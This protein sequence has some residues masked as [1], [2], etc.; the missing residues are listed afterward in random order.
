MQSSLSAHSGICV[1]RKLPTHGR[2][3][4]A[5]R[6]FCGTLR[7]VKK[8]DCITAMKAL[9]EENRLRLVR[10][11]LKQQRSVNELA[12]AL[13]ITQYNVSKH[14]RVLREAGLVEQEK[15]GQQRLYALASTFTQHLADN[16]S[17]LDL[18]CCQFDFKK[19]P[20]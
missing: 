1:K 6:A 20:K 15:Q 3:A 14:L 11:L 10:L 9:G 2:G 7:D 13:K 8:F 19:L 4:L 16:D 5:C 12:E 17:V 18:G